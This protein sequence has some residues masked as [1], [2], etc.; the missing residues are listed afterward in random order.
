MGDHEILNAVF[1]SGIQNFDTVAASRYRGDPAMAD[2]QLVIPATGERPTI[3]GSIVLTAAMLSAAIF[4]WSGALNEL[5]SYFQL[6]DGTNGTPDLRDRFIVGQGPRH[7]LGS[8]SATTDPAIATDA[9]GQ[10]DHGGK[11]GAYALVQNDLPAGPYI[12]DVYASGFT[13]LVND[14][15]IMARGSDRGLHIDYFTSA[16][17]RH[18]HSISGVDAH[19]HQ[20]NVTP[21]YYALA[22]V[23]FKAGI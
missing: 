2:N 11:T 12:T 20:V 9:A 1:P 17:N 16:G 10:H 13:D 7:A 22:F 21:P 19:Q 23:K 15:M 14:S 5:P 8:A 18:F 4:Q 6:C 3:G